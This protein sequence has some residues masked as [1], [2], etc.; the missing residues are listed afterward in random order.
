MFNSQGM[1]AKGGPDNIHDGVDCTYLMEMYRLWCNAMYASSRLRQNSEDTESDR[2]DLRDQTTM[3]QHL[4]N[5]PEAPLC[6]RF[7]HLDTE[8]CCADSTLYP[9]CLSQMVIVK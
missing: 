4:S 8:L 5:R 3:F 6:W 2:L 9:L 1:Q 7:V